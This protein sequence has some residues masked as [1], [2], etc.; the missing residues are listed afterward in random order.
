MCEPAPKLDVMAQPITKPPNLLG[1][2]LI[3]EGGMAVLAVGLAWFGFFQKNQPLAEIPGYSMEAWSSLLVWGVVATFPML[4]YLLVFHFWT[5]AFFRPMQQFVDT[6]LKPLFKNSSVLELLVL[7]LLAGICEE[8]FFRWCLQGGITSVLEGQIGATPA[9]IV[10]LV[11]ASIIFGGCHWVNA[12]YG[13]TTML[14][15]AYLGLTMVW[16]SSWIVPAIAHALFDFVA[17][18]YIARTPARF[19][20]ESV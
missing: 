6:K 4:A 15:G 8:L 19:Q 1:L 20:R 13:I 9:M 2:G 18:I 12:S 14:V 16:T 17:L 3:V 11:V 10:G 7:S 5:P